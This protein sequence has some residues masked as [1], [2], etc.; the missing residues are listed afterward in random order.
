MLTNL[1]HSQLQLPTG[2]PGLD[3]VL[4][5][6]IPESSF[7]V[8]GGGPGTGKSTLAQQF[9]LANVSA[10]RPAVYFFGPGQPCPSAPDQNVHVV[11]LGEQLGERDASRVLDLLVRETYTSHACFVVVD[12]VRGLTHPAVWDDIVLYFTTCGAT[13]LLIADIDESDVASSAADVIVWLSQPASAG[14]SRTLR[15]MK[16]RGQEPI[17]GPQAMRITHE[18]MQVFPRW[19]TPRQRVERPRS[20]TRLSVGIDGL[21][22][23]L[24]GGAPVAA[25]VLAEGPSGSGK[26]VLATQFITECGHDGYPGVVLLFEERPDRFIARAEGMSLE[27]ERLNRCGII[28]VLSFR[29]RDL[30]ADE[31]MY[32]VQRAVMRVGARCVV[33]D[34]TAGLELILNSDNVVDCVWRLLDSLSGMGLTVW[35]ND[36]PAPATRPSLRSFADDVIELRRVERDG[37]LEKYLEVVKV[38][39]RAPSAGAHQYE[40]TERGMELLPRTGQLQH[41]TNG[42]HGHVIG[43]NGF[44][45]SRSA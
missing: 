45:V 27:L 39:C 41:A 28:D 33:I 11:H 35:L 21:D 6:G 29:G 23:L 18:G 38:S 19:P 9:L 43:Y 24:G 31:L 8:I 2:V 15:V 13:S 5:G 26:S 40:I 1:A 17:S 34:S 12:L 37:Q 20:P 42:T 4:G 30:S 7:T 25:S 14:G 22:Q 44:A 16:A 10:E 36:T 32:E 3:E